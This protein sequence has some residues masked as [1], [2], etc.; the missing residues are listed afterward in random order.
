MACNWKSTNSKKVQKI[1]ETLP[2]DTN[3][4]DQIVREAPLEK[5]R[6]VAGERLHKLKQRKEY[7][8]SHEVPR[9]KK[10]GKP[11]ISVVYFTAKEKKEVTGRRSTYEAG[12]KKT[13]TSYRS[14]Y[15]EIEKHTGHYCEYCLNV[16]KAQHA[17]T[18]AVLMFGGIIL[19]AAPILIAMIR[20]TSNINMLPVLA[21][22][23]MAFVG[24][25]VLKSNGGLPISFPDK[26]SLPPIPGEILKSDLINPDDFVS[27]QFVK[28]ARK[29]IVAKT[30]STN[31]FRQTVR[32]CRQDLF[33]KTSS[34][35]QM[36]FNWKGKSLSAESLP[37]LITAR[38]RTRTRH[39][40]N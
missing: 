24:F 37:W 16:Q 36:R 26:H 30:V 7:Y 32:S 35:E 23:A 34:P 21:G 15:S 33:D 12:R 27:S 5:V 40:T 8:A 1:I 29:S 14:T 17:L 39:S 10:C 28:N 20:D 2:N 9:C 6:A 25:T 13:V 3:L 38:H 4:L 18:G 22:A 11:L 19:A 31:R